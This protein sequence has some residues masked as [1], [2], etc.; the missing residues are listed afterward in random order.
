MAAERERPRYAPW[1]RVVL[2]GLQVLGL[3]VGLVLGNATY[4][5]WSEPDPPEV[6]TTTTVVPAVPVPEDTL[7]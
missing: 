4:D 5:R 2:V 1:V 6:V 7:G 3:V